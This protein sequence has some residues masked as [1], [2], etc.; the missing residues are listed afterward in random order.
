[1]KE[2]MGGARRVRVHDITRPLAA[3]TAPWPGDVSFTLQWKETIRGGGLVNLSSISTSPHVGTHVDA[4]IHVRDGEPGA[5][6]LD[7]EPFLGPARVVLVGLGADGLVRPA[8][9]RG[10]D[11]AR[12]PRILLRTDSCPSSL[13]WNPRF[14]ALAPETADLLVRAGAIL[15]GIDTP[16]IDPP[17]SRDLAVHRRLAD[18]AVRWIEGLDLSRVQPGVY[19]LIALPLLIPGGDASPVRA[20]LIER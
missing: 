15:V 17:D 13:E 18:G 20:V 10:L 9:L 4:P 8:A 12:P 14:A 7:L 1:M 5:G 2:E 16:G 3:E 19:E 11:L 6:E